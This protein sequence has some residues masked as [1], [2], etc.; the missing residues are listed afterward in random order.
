MGGKTLIQSPE[1]IDTSIFF[2]GKKFDSIAFIEYAY[3]TFKKT[4]IENS[5]L[6]QG[7][8]VNINSKIL[9][10]SNC[11][12]KCNNN[13]TCDS[14]PWK[15]KEDIFQHI[16]S[17]EDHNLKL[18]KEYKKSRSKKRLHT[19]TP[20]IFS[21]ERTRR[22]TWIRETIENANILNNNIFVNTTPDI[23]NKN[24]DKI[25]IYDRN[26]DF[27]VVLSRTRLSDGNHIIYLNSAY[28][29][30]PKGFLKSFNI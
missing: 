7:N 25:R 21:I 5:V 29:N 16:T 6:F 27:L 14:C 28:N 1:L 4:F 13:I 9:D 22:I 17:D 8:R 3:I 19:R 2:S 30:P 26:R 20:G 18:T 24:E 23:N 10:C 15:D 11:G 12:N